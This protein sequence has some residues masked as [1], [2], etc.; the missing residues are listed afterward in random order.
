MPKRD[1]GLL[2]YEIEQIQNRAIF[3]AINKPKPVCS[4]C[5][6]EIGWS[7]LAGLDI[8][9]AG[10][11]FCSEFCLEQWLDAIQDK[12]DEENTEYPPFDSETSE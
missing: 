7:S 2:P 11:R 6:E 3:E 5:G 8:E 9:Y 1:D 4:N 10:L 12:N